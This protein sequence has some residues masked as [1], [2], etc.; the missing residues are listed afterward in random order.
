[1]EGESEKEIHQTFLPLSYRSEAI[2]PK[3]LDV[4]QLLNENTPPI[5][6]AA[7]KRGGVVSILLSGIFQHMY[8]LSPPLS[9]HCLP[10]LLSLFIKAY[11]HCVSARTHA[12]LDLQSFATFCRERVSHR[13]TTSQLPKEVIITKENLLRGAKVTQRRLSKCPLY[14]GKTPQTRGYCGRRIKKQF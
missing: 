14:R 11:T 8:A 7:V 13:G 4:K 9:R 5:L 3:C 12:N 10:F 2:S 6:G 1:M